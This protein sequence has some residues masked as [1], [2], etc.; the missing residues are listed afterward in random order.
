[1]DLKGYI[2]HLEEV[3]SDESKRYLDLLIKEGNSFNVVEMGRNQWLLPGFVDTHSEY[4]GLRGGG[5]GGGGMEEE[6]MHCGL[7]HVWEMMFSSCSSVC[8]CWISIR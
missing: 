5:G 6:L 8:Q 1:V 4:I 2:I 7:N 3:T